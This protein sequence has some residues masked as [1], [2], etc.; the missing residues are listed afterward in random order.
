M[1]LA[2]TA[3]QPGVTHVLCGARSVGQAQENARAGALA[4]DD[5]TLA[6]MRRDVEAL[7]KPVQE[8]VIA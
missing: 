5:E 2:W 4:L 6:R 8:E 1:V 3:A 7:G